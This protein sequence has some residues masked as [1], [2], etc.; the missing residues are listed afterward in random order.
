MHSVAT[1]THAHIKL[2]SANFNAA[3]FAENN[4]SLSIVVGHHYD[5][6]LDAICGKKLSTSKKH[7]MHKFIAL[8]NFVLL[9]NDETRFTW[10]K[11]MWSN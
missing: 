5:T 4:F 11:K 9:G 3:N 6:P 8:V 1:P 7:G 10:W 2:Y